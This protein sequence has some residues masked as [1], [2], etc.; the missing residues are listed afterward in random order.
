LANI[1]AITQPNGYSA[2][3]WSP[4]GKKIL[5]TKLNYTGLFVLDLITKQI[6]TLN[7]LRGAGFNAAWSSDGKSIFYKHK[8]PDKY[9]KYKSYT[10][11]KSI[12][13]ITRGNYS[14]L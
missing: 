8:T 11:V 2:P 7:M 10:E 9:K 13:I 6:D 5:F 12:T 14:P 4:D 3:K 1:T